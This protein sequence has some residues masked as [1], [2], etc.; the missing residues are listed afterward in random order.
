MKRFGY[1]RDPL[2]LTACACYAGNRWLLTAVLKE[3]FF[4]GYFS[5]TLLIHSALPLILWVQRKLSLR[6]D[7]APPHWVEIALH[8]VVWSVAAEV[9]APHIFSRATGD[10]WDVVAYAGGALFSGLVWQ[11]A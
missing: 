10:V 8:V 6:T 7:D 2:C 11:R 5:Y 1:A 4:R 3:S 9:I